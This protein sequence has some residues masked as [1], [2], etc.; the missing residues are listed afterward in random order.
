MYATT[1]RCCVP[2]ESIVSPKR[3]RK[4]VITKKLINIYRFFLR[5]N[6]LNSKWKLY[7]NA[8]FVRNCK[9][10]YVHLHDS[11]NEN[12]NWIITDCYKV[13]LTFSTIFIY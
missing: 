8:A 11:H 3:G 7:G 5:G 13:P 6:E 4:K 12:N 1:S 2:L 10:K 9:C